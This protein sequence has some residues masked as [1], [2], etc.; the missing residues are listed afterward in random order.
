[1]T[2]ATSLPWVVKAKRLRK[3]GVP[4]SEIAR[5]LGVDRK[6][7]YIKLNSEY[8]DSVRTYQA[9]YRRERYASDPAFRARE[10]ERTKRERL[11]RYAREEADETGVPVE[12]VYERWGVA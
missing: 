2:D 9:R 12:Q 1:M 3:L 10:L 5:R 11:R 6:R 8:A 4:M 7:I